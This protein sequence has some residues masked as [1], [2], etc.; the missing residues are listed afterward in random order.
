MSSVFP[1]RAT[2][3]KRW[4][5]RVVRVSVGVE[6]QQASALVMVILHGYL[7][8]RLAMLCSN[9]AKRRLRWKNIE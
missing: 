6:F 7:V 9:G 1:A 8:W 5:H 2:E 4:T 3:A